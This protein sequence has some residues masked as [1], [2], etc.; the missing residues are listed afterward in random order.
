MNE[1]R[2]GCVTG[3]IFIFCFFSVFFF[4]F[5]LMIRRPPRST[6][7]PYTTLFRSKVDVS[8]AEDSNESLQFVNLLLC[9]V[10]QARIADLVNTGGYTAY[11]NPSECIAGLSNV[12]FFRAVVKSDRAFEHSPQYVKIW[13]PFADFLG[14]DWSGGLVMELIIFSEANSTNPV[15]QFEMKMSLEVTPPVGEEG[16]IPPFLMNTRTVQRNDNKVEFLSFVE[17]GDPF[18]QDYDRYEL[19]S[20]SVVMDDAQG[21]SGASVSFNR[22][23]KVRCVDTDG[24]TPIDP[25]VID[26]TQEG[27]EVVY[28]LTHLFRR[29][30]GLLNTVTE[31]CFDRTNP[32]LEAR[33]YGVYYEQNGV[34]NGYPVSAGQRVDNE[35][36]FGFEYLG[37]SGWASSYGLNWYSGDSSIYM[38]DQAVITTTDLASDTYVVHRSEGELSRIIGRTVSIANVGGAPFSY[39]GNYS[40][41][42]GLIATWDGAGR[43]A[44]D[45]G[46]DRWRIVINPSTFNFEIVAGLVQDPVTNEYSISPE[47]VPVETI[48]QP[49][50]SAGNP[51]S[52][53]LY[54]YAFST[55]MGYDHSL[56]GNP[57]TGSLTYTG[58][59]ENLFQIGRA[60][61]RERV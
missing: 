33:T 46:F 48:N 6:L 38:P 35:K 5:F 11:L 15:G 60:S 37:L 24:F 58:R 53:P 20:A 7:F 14:T 49:V 9:F 39:Y 25:C 36:R 30:I 4:F 56:T 34:V 55:N 26:T 59:Y 12:G 45:F 17:S 8:V 10:K 41:T 51:L 44:S 27:F 31:A 2:D 29:N 52:S 54:L 47:P 3:F 16:D 32:F 19:G 22:E 1:M 21:N 61:C 18:L 42:P 40:G 23:L 50:D 28:N 43:Q 57:A 13:V